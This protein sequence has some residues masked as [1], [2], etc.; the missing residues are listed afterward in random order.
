MPSA[1][2]A[3]AGHPLYASPVPDNDETVRTIV[4][5]GVSDTTVKPSNGSKIAVRALEGDVRQ[6]IETTEQGK[7]S[8][9]D[10]TCQVSGDLEGNGIVEH[11]A[12]E[13]HGHAWS[14]GQPRWSP[15]SGGRL[16]IIGKILGL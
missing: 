2:A 14:G 15:V 6:S 3:M 11:W 4:F 12:I 1:F 13:G 10:F 16:F 5:H 7:T 8:G 9:H